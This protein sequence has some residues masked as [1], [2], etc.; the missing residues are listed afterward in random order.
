MV[1]SCTVLLIYN[2]AQ[3]G[4]REGACVQQKLRACPLAKCGCAV[5]LSAKSAKGTS[6]AGGPIWVV[7]SFS[8]CG[9][10]CKVSG[11]VG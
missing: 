7:Q 11:R 2:M 5:E 1:C 3:A 10:V 4:V 6:S 9:G 8:L